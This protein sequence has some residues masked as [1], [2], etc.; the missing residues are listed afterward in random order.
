MYH[1]DFPGVRL[2]HFEVDELHSV[3]LRLKLAIQNGNEHK[4][5]DEAAHCAIIIA[6]AKRD[7]MIRASAL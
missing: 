6:G 1:P 5:R 2:E 7:A 3:W 4:A